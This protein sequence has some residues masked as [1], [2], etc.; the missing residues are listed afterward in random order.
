MFKEEINEQMKKGGIKNAHQLCKLA[1]IDPRTAY[2]AVNSD[3]YVTP[4]TIAKIAKVFGFDGY[5][6]FRRHV[7]N[8]RDSKNDK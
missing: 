8:K 2:K 7:L 1:R 3:D 4:Q 5:I 6:D